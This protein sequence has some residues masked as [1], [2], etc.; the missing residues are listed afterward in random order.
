L[1]VEHEV[2]EKKGVAWLN[3]NSN[4][5]VDHAKLG[6]TAIALRLEVHW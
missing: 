3:E 5:A 4:V 6:G 1:Q 2:E